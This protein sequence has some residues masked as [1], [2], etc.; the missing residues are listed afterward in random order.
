M[1]PSQVTVVFVAHGFKGL[2]KC[3]CWSADGSCPTCQKGPACSEKAVNV[4]LC[5]L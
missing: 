3:K 4:S 5:T 1:P 2:E